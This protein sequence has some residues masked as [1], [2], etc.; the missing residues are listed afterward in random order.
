[1]KYLL[2]VSLLIVSISSIIFC[3]SYQGKSQYKKNE[4]LVNNYEN[5]VLV[6]MNNC[7]WWVI[8]NED[9]SVRTQIPADF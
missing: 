2:I 7:W 6:F 3:E 1:M 9:G 8:Y 4:R 5:W